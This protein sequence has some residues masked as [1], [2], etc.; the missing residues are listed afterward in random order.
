MREII[1]TIE[2]MKEVDYC[3][4]CGRKLKKLEDENT[5]V[6]IGLCAI[7]RFVSIG[8]A[9]P[10]VVKE[11]LKINLPKI[12]KKLYDDIHHCGKGMIS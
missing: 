5:K 4:Y 12:D 2:E 7:Y 10:K 9:V 6:C 11:I 1:K 3:M 8:D